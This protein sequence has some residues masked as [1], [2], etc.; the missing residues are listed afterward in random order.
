MPDH[1]LLDEVRQ[2]TIVHV[3]DERHDE[4]DQLAHQLLH[5]LRDLHAGH[6]FAHERLVHVQMHQAHLRVGDLGER[7]AVHARE[8]QECHRGQPRGEHRGKVAHHLHVLLGHRLLRQ[9]AQAHRGED[10]LDQRRLEP[11]RAGYLPERVAALRAA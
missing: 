2:E 3:A 11:G 7:L 8:L 1:V 9:V 4:R 6:A 10:A 5:L